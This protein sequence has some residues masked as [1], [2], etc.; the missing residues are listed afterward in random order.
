MIL[1]R[2]NRRVFFVRLAALCIAPR[3]PGEA[4]NMLQWLSRC[5]PGI[6]VIFLI[7]LIIATIIDSKTYGISPVERFIMIYTTLVHINAAVFSCRLIWALICVEKGTRELLRRRDQPTSK[8]NYTGLDNSFSDAPDE[9]QNDDV[10]TNGYTNGDIHK[11][12][13]LEEEA[14]VLHVMILPNYMEDLETLRR[15]LSVLASHPR[16]KKQYEVGA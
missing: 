4:V 2:Y 8:D 16:A 1:S 9:A 10:Y 5:T 3:R 6:T 15:T 13:L 14:E 7:V 12:P 11:A